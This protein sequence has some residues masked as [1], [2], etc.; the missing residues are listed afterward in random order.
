MLTRKDA[1]IQGRTSDLDHT[2][3]TGA[4]PEHPVTCLGDLKPTF[5]V[6]RRDGAGQLSLPLFCLCLQAEL[7]PHSESH[8]FLGVALFLPSLYLDLKQC[9]ELR[10]CI[11]FWMM[12]K[13]F[14]LVLLSVS[15]W[16]LTCSKMFFDKS[17][18]PCIVSMGDSDTGEPARAGW[19]PDSSCV[20]ALMPTLVFS[21]FL[22]EFYSKRMKCKMHFKSVSWVQGVL[23][24]L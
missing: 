7:Q 11:G 18:R 1:L 13:M 19:L 20:H 22:L 17:W 2:V 15:P 8:N 9:R 12:V 23:S 14:S 21:K 10:G 4:N 6:R 5:P 24:V 3:Q 16:S